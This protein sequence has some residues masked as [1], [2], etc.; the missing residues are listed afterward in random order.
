VRILSVLDYHRAVRSPP[1]SPGD[2]FDLRVSLR[3]IEPTIWRALSV[4][5]AVPLA[6]LHEILQVAFGWQNSHLHDFHVGD[7]RFGMA[8]TEH[9]LLS[10]D[11]R[12]APL[13]AIA[14][15][16]STLVYQYD[17][18]DSW[19]HDIKVERVHGNGEETIRCTAGARACP[20]EDCGGVPGYMHLL[21]VLANPKDDEHAEMK[22]WAPRSFNPEKFDVVAVNKKF[23]TLSK[24]LARWRK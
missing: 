23:A 13:G 15:E 4:P 7:I 18:G 21:E 24:R 5:A 12:A 22:Q 14:H 10:V 11:E 20:P 9:E 1:P 8:D 17:F 6:A 16:G 2:L 3:H 19:E